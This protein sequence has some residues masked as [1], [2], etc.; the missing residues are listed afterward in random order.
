MKRVRGSPRCGGVGMQ[1]FPLGPSVEL[2]IR[3]RSLC[4]VCRADRGAGTHAD[5]ATGALGGDPDRGHEMC[6]G[7]AKG[8]WVR[9]ATSPAL[10]LRCS[11]WGDEACAACAKMGG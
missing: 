8:R 9:H 7:S 2:P 11:I 5:A 6:D 4:V 10:G 3:P 1:P